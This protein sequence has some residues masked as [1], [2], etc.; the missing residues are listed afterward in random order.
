MRAGKLITLSA[1]AVLV[2]GTSLATVATDLAIGQTLQSGSSMHGSSL[3]KGSAPKKSLSSHMGPQKTALVTGQQHSQKHHSIAPSQRTGIYAQA[4]TRE[5]GATGTGAAPGMQDRSARV[6]EITRNIP[7]VSSVGTAVRIDA[8]VPRTVRQAAAP[9]P[10]EVQRMHPRFRNDRAFKYR[11]QVVIVNP[12]T[13]RIVAIIK[14]P[15]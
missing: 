12:T 2:G 7:R 15:A 13:S 4:S 5:L 10:P 9:L 8:V 6:R 3:N 11:D 1:V 14:A